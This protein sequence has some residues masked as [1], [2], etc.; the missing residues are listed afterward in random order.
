MPP[1]LRHRVDHWKRP[2][3]FIVDKTPVISDLDKGY[4][5]DLLSPNE[6]IH[7]DEVGLIKSHRGGIGWDKGED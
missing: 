4:E 6:H 2:Q 7:D 1:S 3:E 5:F